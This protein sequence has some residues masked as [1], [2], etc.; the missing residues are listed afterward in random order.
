MS[1]S[2]RDY[3]N[4]IDVPSPTYTIS[5]FPTP[6]EVRPAESKNISGILKSCYGTIPNVTKYSIDNKNLIIKVYP[7]SNSFASETQVMN[8][9]FLIEIPNQVQSGEYVI[10]I[11]ATILMGSTLSGLE[12]TAGIPDG[13]IPDVIGYMNIQ[14]TLTFKVLEPLDFTERFKQF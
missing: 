1:Y 10:P 6:I 11:T 12:F 9:E 7:Q 14:S 3:T 5:T 13:L 4:W 2:G 8:A